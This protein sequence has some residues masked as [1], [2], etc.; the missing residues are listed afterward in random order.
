MKIRREMTEESVLLASDSKRLA[1]QMGLQVGAVVRCRFIPVPGGYSA[2]KETDEIIRP[3]KGVVTGKYPFIFSV[4]FDG[5]D[6]IENF[7][8]PQI[9]ARLGERIDI[10]KRG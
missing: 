10:V 3:R 9:F 2:K 1:E 8:Y 5:N 7:R 4:K 6:Y